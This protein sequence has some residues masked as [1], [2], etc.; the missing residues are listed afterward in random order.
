MNPYVFDPCWK[1]PP[2]ERK[3]DFNF[4]GF[5]PWKKTRDISQ[6]SMLSGKRLN[7]KIVFKHGYSTLPSTNAQRDTIYALSTPPG[8]G[9]V[10][11]VR[12]SGPSA[13]EVWRRMVKCRKAQEA[14]NKEPTPW[15]LHRCRVIHP[16]KKTLIDDGLAVYFRG[17]QIKILDII[18]FTT[19]YCSSIFIYDTEYGWTSCSLG[20][21]TNFFVALFTL[22]PAH[23]E[24]CWSRRIHPSSF[25]GRPIGSYSGWRFTWSDWRWHWTTESL[26]FDKRFGRW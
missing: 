3:K 14:G 8:K 5:V 9:G 15:R 25:T 6:Y 4:L 19:V 22:L 24:T 26:G 18:G 7:S 10:A 2:S 11:I 21:G 12:V 13:L 23:P 1:F 17:E 16:E 20:K